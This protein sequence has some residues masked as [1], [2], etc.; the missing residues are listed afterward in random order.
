MEKISTLSTSRNILLTVFL[1]LLLS[2][3]AQSQVVNYQD[4]W[5]ESGFT[6]EMENTGGVQINFSITQFE[7]EE[8]DVGGTMMKLV[9]LPGNWVR[10]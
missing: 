4:S 8:V 3:S 1:S 5:G 7:I 10:K 2:F 6:L 9:H